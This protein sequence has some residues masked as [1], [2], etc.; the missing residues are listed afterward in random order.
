M[1]CSISSAIRAASE[2]TRCSTWRFP[3]AIARKPSGQVGGLGN[4]RA[5]VTS[6]FEL[7]IAAAQAAWSGSAL[8]AAASSVLVSTTSTGSRD[9]SRQRAGRLRRG[10]GAR[11]STSRGRPARV[12]AD[13]WTAQQVVSASSA[14]PTSMPTPR[15]VASRS[16]S[17][18][19]TSS[20]RARNSAHPPADSSRC[21]SLPASETA[22]RVGTVGHL[23]ARMSGDHRK[24]TAACAV[25]GARRRC[26]R[27]WG[28]RSPGYGR[29]CRR[30]G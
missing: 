29:C 1:R 19:N 3:L 14:I 26:E 25:R 4:T 15:R 17:M 18:G 9:R 30:G 8:S 11:P 23:V 13:R 22:A 6:R 12:P 10:R 16:P 28:Y 2:A 21:P 7:V 27:G 24:R 5:V 20:R